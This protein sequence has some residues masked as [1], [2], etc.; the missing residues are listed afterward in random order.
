MQG[1]GLYGDRFQYQGNDMLYSGGIIVGH[2]S[3]GVIGMIGCRSDAQGVVI[4]D[5]VNVTPFSGFSS[6]N[7][8]D[9]I[10]EAV[11]NDSDAPSPLN[12]KITQTTYSR[13]GDDYIFVKYNIRNNSTQ[14]HQGIYAGIFADWDIGNYAQNRGGTDVSRN[15]AFQYDQS[16][17]NDDYVGIRYIDNLVG[18][19][20]CSDNPSYDILRDTLFNWMKTVAPVQSYT[21][22]YRI[23]LSCGPFNIS[24]GDYVEAVFIVAAG[25]N[26]SDLKQNSD[27]A[28]DLWTGQTVIYP[29]L[30]DLRTLGS[31]SPVKNQLG[32]STCGAFAATHAAESAWMHHGYSFLDL[33]EQNIRTGHGYWPYMGMSSG[34]Y[35][36]PEG[37]ITYYTRGDGPILESDDPYTTDPNATHNS[38]FT[39]AFYVDKAFMLDYNKDTLKQYL[40]DYGGMHVRFYYNAD[41]YNSSTYIYCCDDPQYTGYSN[42]AVLV[43]GW[44]NN[45][46]TPAGEGAWIIKN[47]WGANWGDNGYFYIAYDDVSFGKDIIC[48]P[49]VK[50]QELYNKKYCY[51]RLGKVWTLG[52]TSWNH[53]GYGLVKYVAENDFILKQ[54]ATWVAG[55][56]ATINIEIYDEKNGNDLSGLLYSCNGIQ[57]KHKGY[58]SFETDQIMISQGDDFYIKVKYYVPSSD[59][60]IPVEGYKTSGDDVMT[61]PVIETGKCWITRNPVY[62]WDAIGQ[63]TNYLYDC[64]I[65]AIGSESLTTVTSNFDVTEGWNMIS[66]PVQA[67]DMSKTSLFPNSVSSCFMYNNGYTTVNILETGPGYWLKFGSPQ[68]VSISGSAVSYNV[69]LLDGWNMI[70]PFHQDVPVASISTIPSGIITS[71]FYAFSAGY[72]TTNLLEPGKGYRV[73]TS[74]A[75]EM[76]YNSVAR[77]GMESDDNFASIQ[78]TDAA[79]NRAVLYLTE[80]NVSEKYEMPP[81]PPEGIFDARFS[82]GFRAEKI[83]GSG[84]NIDISG[85]V[86]P[87]RVSTSDIAVLLVINDNKENNEIR[88]NDGESVSLNNGSLTGLTIFADNIPDNFALEQNYPNPFNPET[89]I[90][91]RVAKKCLVTLGVFDILGRKIKTL[92]NEVKEAGSYSVQFYGDNLTTGIY[93][94]SLTAGQYSSTKKMMLI[95]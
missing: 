50:S 14:N 81:K 5:M 58:Y 73:K 71:A 29:E 10:T 9:Q 83:S 3:T 57:L 48:F 88:L 70:G 85:F 89:S 53:V 32:L 2:E 91:F 61:D 43:V 56:N 40:M 21:G 30:F 35:V 87:L 38:G 65:R 39:P 75:G 45:I 63:G 54:V 47:S 82:S 26:E 86:S 62:G 49:S 60:P 55:T 94:Y 28:Y 25:E 72:Q 18:M 24:A 66:A 42:H 19:R 33:S 68:S 51:D 31:V 76:T 16:G 17:A 93:I 22:D 11:F 46:I 1:Q 80:E 41:F 74:Q 15:L 44:D 64:C 8:F 23:Y 27:E 13:N 34:L 7:T 12:L 95:K 92:V 79:G 20:V 37:Y 52:S 77:K 59:N 90:T 69:S 84:N 6:N 36:P 67:A 78:L 4:E